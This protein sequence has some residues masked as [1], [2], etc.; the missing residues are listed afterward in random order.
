MKSDNAYTENMQN[1]VTDDAGTQNLSTVMV[2]QNAIQVK[3]KRRHYNGEE[4]PQNCTL[5]PLGFR[6]PAGGPNHGHGNRQHAQKIGK[7]RACGSRDTP[8]DR[9]Q[10]DAPQTDVL[11]T[12]LRHRFR[13]R[14][15]H[16]YVSN[17]ETM[18]LI[19]VQIT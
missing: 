13:R 3:V 8:T 1:F 19:F 11:I 7:D 16:Q 10:T 5:L 2:S 18:Y 9:R 6:H 15:K 14:S 17:T 12:I 4:N